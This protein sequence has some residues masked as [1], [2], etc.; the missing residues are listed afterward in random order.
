M[1]KKLV[2]RIKQWFRT[3]PTPVITRG[4]TEQLKQGMLRRWKG[5]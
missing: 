2:A 4:T 5:S 3:A 1:F